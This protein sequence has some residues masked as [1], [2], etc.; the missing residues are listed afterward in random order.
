MKTSISRERIVIVGGGAGGISLASRLLR[1]GVKAQITVIDPAEVHF[2]QPYWTLVGG[3]VVQALDSAKLMKDV[4]P[5]GV[6]WLREAVVDLQAAKKQLTTD[7]GR[8]VEFDYLVLAPG[9][10][11]DWDKIPGFRETLGKGGVCSIY[12]FRQAEKT[13]EMV[14]TFRGGHAIFNG[15]ATPIKCGGAPMKI[16]FLS[17]ETFR[18]TGVRGRT[19]VKFK[20]PG[21]VIFGVK[22]YADALT[23]VVRERDI[24]TEFGHTLQRIEPMTKE[25]TFTVQKPGGSQE[26]Y[27]ER[28]DLMHVTPH[29]SAPDWIKRSDV[30]V[31]DG[32]LKGW[33]KVDAHTLQSPDFPYV[34]ALGDVA[35]LPGHPKTGA[36]VRKQYPVVAK[37]LQTVMKGFPPTN[38]YD[39]YSS[40]PIVTGRGKLILAEFV[41]GN[42]IKSSFPSFM[43]SDTER[44]DSWLLKRYGLAPMYW[45]GMLKGLV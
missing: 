28:Y 24:Q 44:Y 23:K 22:E 45:Y 37:N 27:T 40:C 31:A 25:A 7:A 35:G 8:I 9:I 19:P 16:M 20:T 10:Q 4:M 43:P 1:D 26:T 17:E 38:F 12:D 2:Y 33:V 42:R 6:E 34:F 36:A 30:A 29:M 18:E 39:G 32:P 21:G 41:Y 14:R 15:A 11:I 3:G 5:S 13:W